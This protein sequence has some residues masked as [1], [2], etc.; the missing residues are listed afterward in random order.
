MTATVAGKIPAPIAAPRRL[1]TLP[2]RRPRVSWR[3]A[4]AV[5]LVAVAAAFVVALS[6]AAVNQDYPAGVPGT[7]T[8]V[9]VP[10]HETAVPPGETAPHWD[11]SVGAAPISLCP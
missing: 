7:D 9:P 11:S 10:C 2:I 1:I 8:T 3:K 6:I 4:A 5:L